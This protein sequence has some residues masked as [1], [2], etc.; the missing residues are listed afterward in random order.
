V[1]AASL[2]CHSLVRFTFAGLAGSVCPFCRCK[3]KGSKITAYQPII[4]YR[5]LKA[6]QIF[7]GKEL[8][9]KHVLLTDEEG[10]IA[11]I[12]PEE[13]A[14]EEVEI[15]S[16]ILSPGFVNC[17][18]H[19]ELSHLK[20]GIPPHTGLVDFV[21]QVMQVRHT[22]PETKMTAMEA[23]AAELYESGTVAIGDICNTSDSVTLKETSRIR[24][25]NFIEVS[26]FVAASA[27]KRLSAAAEVLQEF[28]TGGKQPASIVPHAAYSVSRRLFALLNERSAAQI[29][30]IHNQETGAEDQLYRNR[31]GD[32]LKLYAH[33]GIDISS[34]SATGKTSFQSWLPYFTRGQQIISVH[35]TFISPE[36]IAF[37]KRLPA[38]EANLYFCICINA[39]LYIENRLP[40]L[41]LLLENN[42]RIVI[43][44]DSYASNHQL[45][46][47]EEINSIRQHFPS[48]PLQTIL[49]WATF[50][51]AAALDITDT[52][53]SFKKGKKPG[54]VLIENTGGKLSPTKARRIL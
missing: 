48:I 29:I 45:N 4:L 33:L 12:I 2:L 7:T 13:A 53:G 42:C 39:N 10:T 32:F 21:Q 30:S 31:S 38:P 47:M 17:H 15:F 54:I 16:G 11:G 23:A 14:G 40:P 46:M 37:M 25:R 35:N 9:D 26:G 22:A 49:G 6:D 19:I 5:K 28:Q 36:D 3:R 8:L 43:G 27:E 18:C 41:A 34:F 52:H 1:P 20:N 44:T 24:W 51:G 50:N